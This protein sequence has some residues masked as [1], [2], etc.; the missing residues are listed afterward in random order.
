MIY[1]R[2][3]AAEQVLNRT[4]SKTSFLKNKTGAIKLPFHLF[5][6]FSVNYQDNAYLKKAVSMIIRNEF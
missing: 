6:Y 2:N 1:Y 5:F 4:L 3:T